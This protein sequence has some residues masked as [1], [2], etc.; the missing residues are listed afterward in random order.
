MQERV[1]CPVA[2]RI[3]VAVEDLAVHRLELLGGSVAVG[4]DPVADFFCGRI[5]TRIGVVAIR[6]IGHVPN[7]GL[8]GGERIRIGSVAVPVYVSAILRVHTFVGAGVAVVVD[9][10]ADLHAMIPRLWFL[11]V[12]VARNGHRTT[13]RLAGL[14]DDV[15]VALPISIVVEE[16][17]S[18]DT[19]VCGHVA[20]LIDPVA[21]LWR[22]RVDRLVVVIAIAV[23]ERLPGSHLADP[24]LNTSPHAIAI[25]VEVDRDGVAD[26]FV[27]HLI[28][29]VVLAVAQ[30]LGSWRRG[31]GGVVAVLITPREPLKRGTAE[32]DRGAEFVTESI[33]ITVVPPGHCALG[34][35]SDDVVEVGV[36][37][38]T[39]A[40]VVFPVAPLLGFGIDLEVVVV[41]VRAAIEQAFAALAQQNHLPTEPISVAIDVVVRGVHG[42][43]VEVGVVRQTVAV[44]VHAVAELVRSRVHIFRAPAHVVA[45][46]CV[47]NE[48]CRHLAATLAVLRVAVAIAI[49]VRVELS[50]AREH[51]IAV[52]VVHATVTVV[53]SP[54]ADFVRPGVHGGF[55]I[56][57]V[58]T[59]GIVLARLPLG[60]R[61][62][63]VQEPLLERGV[64]HALQGASRETLFTVV[65][66]IAVRVNVGAGVVELTRRLPLITADPEENER[67]RHHP[68]LCGCKHVHLRAGLRHLERF[69]NSSDALFQKHS[70][71]Q[72]IPFFSQKVN[73]SPPPLY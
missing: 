14:D 12:A 40:V 18:G 61:A 16:E 71:P 3:A 21:H 63:H 72:F 67:C 68:Q 64:R 39:I 59:E 65:V 54:V 56:I 33:A 73:P 2:V 26:F 1:P 62:V 60:A 27:D 37:R 28:A 66:G 34:V 24:K 29:V 15:R 35:R 19:F 69:S 22:V 44:V 6:H 48:P 57:A 32:V 41:A 31:C 10:V 7:R 9:A 17:V 53:V 51:Q 11:I 49:G 8:A 30:L 4:V 20:V 25:K 45:V 55:E 38:Q 23:G 47:C 52:R 36:V 46:A 70:R 42:R 58:V 50:S 13:T 43:A 5:H